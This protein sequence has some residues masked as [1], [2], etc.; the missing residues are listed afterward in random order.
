[1]R[2]LL[3]AV[4]VIGALVAIPAV[5]SSAAVH[6]NYPLGKHGQCRPGY[7]KRLRLRWVD[8]KGRHLKRRYIDCVWRPTVL[9][10]ASPSSP[11]VV[12]GVSLDPSYLQ[13]ATN[14]LQ[15]TWS[16]SASA[17]SGGQSVNE[18]P[19]GVL[20]FYSSGVLV[21]STS[22]G[23]YVSSSA[24]TVTYS[25]YGNQ[26]VEVAYESGSNRVSTGEETFNIENPGPYP[27][28]VCKPQATPNTPK[29]SSA[30]KGGSSSSPPSP[31][32]PGALDRRHALS[33]RLC[34]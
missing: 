3:G 2:R 7:A 5:S 24:A 26:V 32:S 1:M 29:G 14:P 30:S 17:T 18:L 34:L 9:P 25:G 23:G 28:S 27:S 8:A 21:K 4:L 13:S 31:P 16:Y 12:L 20:D 22:V 11:V 10:V 6:T 15:V 33:P 19:A